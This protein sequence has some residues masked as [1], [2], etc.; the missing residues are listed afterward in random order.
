MK[1]LTDAVLVAALSLG[2]ATA[3]LAQ[4]AKTPEE[5]TTVSSQAPVGSLGGVRFGA[6]VA[7]AVIAFAAFSAGDS[8]GTS[9]TRNIQ[10]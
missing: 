10:P 6:F 9:G 5:R 7:A 3:G 2:T 8:G 1:R 4:Q